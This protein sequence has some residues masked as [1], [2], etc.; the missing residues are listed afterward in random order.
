M[1]ERKP[2]LKVK[3]LKVYYHT[4]RGSVRAVDGVSFTMH[5]GESFGIVGESGCGKSTMAMAL[6]GLVIL[7]GTIEGG[8]IFL[9]GIDILTL[10]SELIRKIRWSQISFIPDFHRNSS[11]GD[12]IGYFK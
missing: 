6:L 11:F 2:I 1:T 12:W 10:D 5:E 3:D 7:P 8:Q 9:D 4:D